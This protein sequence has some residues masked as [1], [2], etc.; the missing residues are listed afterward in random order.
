MSR[1]E[2][3][4]EA[5]ETLPS[6]EKISQL[7]SITVAA[8][9]VIYLVLTLLRKLCAFVL[10]SQRTQKS[11]GNRCNQQQRTINVSI[12]TFVHSLQSSPSLS[13][14]SSLSDRCIESSS[15]PSF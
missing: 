4:T 1:G 8:L 2:E 5:L 14:S 10:S 11:W 9:R 13:L 7:T 6:F 12:R 15:S 3:E